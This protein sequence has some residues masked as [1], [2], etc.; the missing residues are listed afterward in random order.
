MARLT[1]RAVERPAASFRQLACRLC[2]R[3]L[4]QRP[5]NKSQTRKPRAVKP[6]AVPVLFVSVDNL[7]PFDLLTTFGYGKRVRPIAHHVPMSECN[8]DSFDVLGI[9][10]RHGNAHA[11]WKTPE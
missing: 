10:Q 1:M 3:R 5:C 11:V 4:I 8:K 6:R 9:A 2:H 7:W